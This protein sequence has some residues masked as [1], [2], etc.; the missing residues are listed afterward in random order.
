MSPV[1]GIIDHAIANR[2][3]VTIPHQHNILD[4]AALLKRRD[5]LLEALLIIPTLVM[6]TLHELLPAVDSGGD[7]R[8]I[9]MSL[10]RRKLINEILMGN[11][12]KIKGDNEL[13]HIRNVRNALNRADLGSN[14]WL[15][16]IIKIHRWR[17]RQQA[18]TR[19]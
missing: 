13:E 4:V 2:E 18:L 5:S 17:G 15:V 11:D 16:D 7:I 9:L 14:P 10:E 1:R 6:K 12:Q 8:I 3:S 19:R